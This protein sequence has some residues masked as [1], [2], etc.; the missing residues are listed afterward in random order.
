MQSSLHPNM[1]NCSISYL[2]ST[3]GLHAYN[4]F[5]TNCSSCYKANSGYNNFLTEFNNFK[6]KYD[7]KIYCS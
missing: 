6:A 3:L 7:T 2:D 4:N 5:N 1:S